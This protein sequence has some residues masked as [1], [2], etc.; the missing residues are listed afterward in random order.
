MHE[1]RSASDEHPLEELWGKLMLADDA[2]RLLTPEMTARGLFDASVEAQNWPN[3][4]QILAWLL[5]KRAAVWWGC[6]CSWQATRPDPMARAETALQAALAWVQDPSEPRRRQAEAAAQR[7]TTYTSAG[8]LA[9]AAF[10]AEGNVSAPH[11]PTVSPPEH[12]TARL[13]GAAILRAAAERDAAN[14][15]LHQRKSLGLGLE[16][17]RRRL[18][19]TGPATAATPQQ[20]VAQ[21]ERSAEDWWTAAAEDAGELPAVVEDKPLLAVAAAPSAE[22]EGF[23]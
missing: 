10:W 3:A 21:R 15:N 7:A 23:R 8:C 14:A 1:T 9:M 19:W 16:V 17:A 22:W 2:R 4:I 6:L 13:V 20:P 11:L 18:L 5:P 12:V